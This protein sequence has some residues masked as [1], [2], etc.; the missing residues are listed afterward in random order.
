MQTGLRPEENVA[1]KFYIISTLLHWM[2]ILMSHLWL[3]SDFSA[4]V[5]LLLIGQMELTIATTWFCTQRPTTYVRDSCKGGD[6]DK[7]QL[8]FDNSYFN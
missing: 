7:W 3:T 6:V 5:R 8:C 2:L 4:R 1:C